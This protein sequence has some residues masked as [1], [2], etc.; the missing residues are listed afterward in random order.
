MIELGLGNRN[1][2]NGKLG[3][4]L[5]NQT[6]ATSSQKEGNFMEMLLVTGT[7]GGSSGTSSNPSRPGA[8]SRVSFLL[9]QG[10]YIV[11]GGGG[12]FRIILLIFSIWYRLYNKLMGRFSV[13]V[14]RVCDEL[15][16]L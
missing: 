4:C 9:P 8:K 12:R 11:E 3:I 15:A 2:P 10:S 13:V 14:T 1:I 5:G 16:Y 6:S 7:D